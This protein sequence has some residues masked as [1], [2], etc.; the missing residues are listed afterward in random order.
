MDQRNRMNILLYAVFDFECDQSGS[1][2]VCVHFSHFVQPHLFLIS[3]VCVIAFWNYAL[4]WYVLMRFESSKQAE[5]KSS[6]MPFKRA[7]IHSSLL[8]SPLSAINDSSASM[9]QVDVHLTISAIYACEW[10]K[11]KWTF[12][13]SQNVKHSNE[14]LM[15][16]ISWYPIEKIWIC[17]T[18]VAD[19]GQSSQN[20]CDNKQV[21]C[22]ISAS[23]ISE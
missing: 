7:S 14:M 9:T 18:L 3:T 2:F 23:R 8:L 5:N 6:T 13:N 17:E 12:H 21:I 11:Y 22:A 20:G 15:F 16:H 1:L 10:I 4:A 19:S